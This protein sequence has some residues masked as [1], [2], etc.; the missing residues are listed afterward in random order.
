MLLRGSLFV[1][2]SCPQVEVSL[3]QQGYTSRANISPQVVLVFVVLCW[4]VLDFVFAFHLPALGNKKFA[5]LLL[6]A[7]VTQ[8]SMR[9]SCGLSRL[10]AFAPGEE[11]GRVGINENTTKLL[12]FSTQPL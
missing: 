8:C 9:H 1:V 5:F 6:S 3:A 2:V 4:F 7:G 10:E 12:K 11:L